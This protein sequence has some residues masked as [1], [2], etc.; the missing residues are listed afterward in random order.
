MSTTKKILV[1]SVG[2]LILS[3]FCITSFLVLKLVQLEE[4]LSVMQ[5]STNTNIKNTQEELRVAVNIDGA[6]VLGDDNAPV[7]IVEFSDF[8]CT[9]CKQVQPTLQ[10]LK[11]KYGSRIKFVFKQYPLG[12]IHKY[13]VTSAVASLC[14]NEQSKF[15]EYHDVLFENANDSGSLNPKLLKSL[16]K[17]IGLNTEQFN[18]CLDSKKYLDKVKMDFEEG[19]NIKVTGTPTFFIN[20]QMLQGS[21]GIEEFERIIEEELAITNN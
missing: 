13:A 16:A 11:N 12:D 3:L 15:W 7:T 8:E 6:P 5:T 21:Q 4:K 9:F 1:I 18:K 20:G 17:Q 2:I 10:E 19:V 14:A